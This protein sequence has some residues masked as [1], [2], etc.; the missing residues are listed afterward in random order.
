M[1]NPVV[2]TQTPLD[3]STKAA[4]TAYVDS[5]V[6]TAVGSGASPLPFFAHPSIDGQVT[7]VAW[8]NAALGGTTNAIILWYFVLPYTT[9]FKNISFYV[10]GLDATNK[11]DFGIYNKSGS[12]LANLGAAIYGT[13][14]SKTVA[15]AQTEV[16]LAAGAY[17]FAITSNAAGSLILETCNVAGTNFYVIA[18]SKTTTPTWFA[19]ATASTGG[20]LASTITAPTISSSS[21]LV[22]WRDNTSTAVGAPIF[23]LTDF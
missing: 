4:S 19:S 16:T 10:A 17:F 18:N 12:L 2:G 7:T 5:A 22:N 14:G 15:I 3:N 11:Y 20:A 13:A 21:N 8:T 9:K 6:S 23:V 1:T